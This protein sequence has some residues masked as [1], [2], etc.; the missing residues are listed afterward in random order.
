MT[1]DEHEMLKMHMSPE[2]DD[3]SEHGWE[4][5]TNAA[6]T[7]LLKTCLSKGG[8]KGAAT[9]VSSQIKTL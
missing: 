7:S 1:D 8:S 5:V 9:N 2:I 4:E 3:E 6:M